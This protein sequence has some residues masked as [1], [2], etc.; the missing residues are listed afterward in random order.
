VVWE[1]VHSHVSDS[2]IQGVALCG[3]GHRVWLC[4]SPCG[5]GHRVWLCT[6]PCGD[7]WV[8]A[9]FIVAES[10]RHYSLVSL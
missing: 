6:S 8:S 2:N 9:L 5:H 7:T 4:T 1:S 10:L 3:H